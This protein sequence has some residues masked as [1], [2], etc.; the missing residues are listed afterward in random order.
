MVLLLFALWPRDFKYVMSE[1]AL[2]DYVEELREFY[3]LNNALSAEEQEVAIL[4]DLRIELSNQYRV[5]AANN[6]SINF[7]RASK[8]ATAFCLLVFA[9]ILAF[10]MIATILVTIKIE[11]ASNAGRQGEDRRSAPA[12]T[13]SRPA[14][15]SPSKAVP[16]AGPDNKKGG[17]D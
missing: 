4:E 6:R 5:G 12:D 15:E 7:G 10:A 8:R 16:P 14:G 11:G 1:P 2:H 3:S 13:G 9:L 17:M